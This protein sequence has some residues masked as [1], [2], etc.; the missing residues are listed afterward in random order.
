MEGIKIKT[1]YVRL[2]TCL[3]VFLR[4]SG[5]QCKKKKKSSGERMFISSM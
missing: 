5:N 3:E 4:F 1:S 2:F